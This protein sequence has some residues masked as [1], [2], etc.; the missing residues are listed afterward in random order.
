[1]IHIAYPN[2][3]HATSF[4]ENTNEFHFRVFTSYEFGN[5][6]FIEEQLFAQLMDWA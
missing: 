1:V 3:F 6:D 2:I 4:A 5:C